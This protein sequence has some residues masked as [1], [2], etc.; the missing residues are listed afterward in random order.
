MDVVTTVNGLTNLDELVEFEYVRVLKLLLL[1]TIKNSVPQLELLLHGAMNQKFLDPMEAAKRLTIMV[2]NQAE[3]VF[4]DSRQAQDKRHGHEVQVAYR[5]N[6][7]R[8]VLA[9]HKP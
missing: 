6:E 5:R 1:G 4:P 3:M 2:L 9:I 8:I 7:S